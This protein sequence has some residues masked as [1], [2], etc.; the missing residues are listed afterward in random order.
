MEAN[1]ERMVNMNGLEQIVTELV[2]EG[3][4]EELEQIIKQYEDVSKR[5][6]S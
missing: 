3:Y 2:K 5:K 1:K 4:S 6:E